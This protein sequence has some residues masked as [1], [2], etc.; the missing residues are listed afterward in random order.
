LE[1]CVLFRTFGVLIVT[2]CGASTMSCVCT[3][4]LHGL[5][6]ARLLGNGLKMPGS[7]TMS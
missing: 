2:M 6:Y 5:E 3:A 1:V 4:L 7:S